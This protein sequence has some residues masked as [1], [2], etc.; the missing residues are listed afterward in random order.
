MAIYLYEFNFIILSD[1]IMMYAIKYIFN[2]H[3][4]EDFFL[5]YNDIFVFFLCVV[6]YRVI[7]R[8]MLLH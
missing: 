1:L 2:S 8:F 7:K 4:S 5:L 6:R 3:R